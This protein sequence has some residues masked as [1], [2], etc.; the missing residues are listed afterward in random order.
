VG[1]VDDDTLFYIE[2]RGIPFEDAQ[3]LVVV[4]FLQEVLDR[5]TLPE[6]RASLEA[7]IAAELDREGR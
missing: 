6:V 3:R 2:S 7:T 5:V 1:P 4:G